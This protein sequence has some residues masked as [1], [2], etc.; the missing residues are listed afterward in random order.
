MR[1]SQ[2]AAR[3]CSQCSES[4]KMGPDEGFGR[5]LIRRA[6]LTSDPDTFEKYALLLAESTK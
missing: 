2:C 3:L 4:D 6:K 1:E 5:N